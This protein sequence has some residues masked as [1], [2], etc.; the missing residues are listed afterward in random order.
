MTLPRNLGYKELLGILISLAN[1]QNRWIDYTFKLIKMKKKIISMILTLITLSVCSQDDIKTT[2]AH[3][4][5]ALEEMYSDLPEDEKVP[6]FKSRQKKIDELMD[7]AKKK[8][9]SNINSEMLSEDEV[10]SIFK[11]IDSLLTEQYYL[12]C[13]KVERLSET[14][15][16]RKLSEFDCVKHTPGFR[17]K[18]LRQNNSSFYYGI[19][20][21]LGA[22][23]Y[24]SIGEILNFP[25]HIVEVPNHNFVRWEFKNESFINWDNNSGKVFNNNDFRNGLTPTSSSTFDTQEERLNHYLESMKKDEFKGYYISL[26]ASS[27]AEKGFYL[28]AEELFKKAISYRPYDA[29]ACN[30]LSWMYVTVPIFKN[31]SNYKKAYELSSK[32]DKQLPRNI[33]YKDTYSC[34]CAAVGEFKKAIR[35][36]SDAYN[37]Q[38]RIEGFTEKKTCLDIGEKY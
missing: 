3:E 2:L 38:L 20:C 26:I 7:A 32:V 16:P 23:L 29:L 8:F 17:G 30:N 22:I 11:T 25:I 1:T 18:F 27:L 28:K 9:G 5:L 31:D 24:A 34:A 10:I 6:L 35:I 19:D 21:D 36:E 33:T 14:L 4:L 13:I 12:V 15:T 37:K